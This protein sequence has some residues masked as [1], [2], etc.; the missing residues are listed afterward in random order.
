MPVVADAPTARR[1]AAPQIMTAARFYIERPHCS[2]CWGVR[3]RHARKRAPAWRRSPPFFVPV[4]GCDDVALARAPIQFC[5]WRHPCI[6]SG[7]A[8]PPGPRVRYGRSSLDESITCNHREAGQGACGPTGIGVKVRSPDRRILETRFL[9]STTCG[10]VRPFV[11]TPMGPPGAPQG[12][13][14]PPFMPVP[15][16]GKTKW[17]ERPRHI[18]WWS[19][20]CAG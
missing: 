8:P 19:V 14:A 12:G 2:P 4:L 17:R 10:G 3:R 6:F 20:R 5:G 18:G 7:A 16:N 15:G 9:P 1:L 11:L 13:A